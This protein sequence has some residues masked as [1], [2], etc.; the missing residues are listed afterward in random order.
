MAKLPKY[1]QLTSERFNNYTENKALY[2]GDA[3]DVFGLKQFDYY[4]KLNPENPKLSYVNYN[5]FKILSNAIADL[6]WAN[7]EN[8]ITL[9]T[10][11][12]WYDQWAV[13]TSLHTKLY[14]GTLSGSYW[15]DTVYK[16]CV[17]YTNPSEKDKDVRLYQVNPGIWHPKYDEGNPSR[18]IENHTLM[19]KKSILDEAGKEK[20]VAVLLEKYLWGS[21]QYEAY[22]GKTVEDAESVNPKTYFENEL[23]DVLVESATAETTGALTYQTNTTKPLVFHI[24]NFSLPDELYGLSDYSQDIKSVV[25]SINDGY[26]SI[27]SVRKRHIDPMLVVPE[28]VIK[29]SI[30]EIMS[31]TSNQQAQAYGYSSVNAFQSQN[32]KV[33]DAVKARVA[34]RILEKT[35]LM[36][37]PADG[38]QVKPEYITWDAKLEVAFNQIKDLKKNLG[39]QSE[40]AAVLLEPDVVTGDISGVTLERLASPTLNKAKRKIMYLEK[41]IKDIIFTAQQLAKTTQGVKNVPAGEPEVPIVKFN[42]VLVKSLVEVIDRNQKLIETGLIS[43]IDAMIDVFNY[44]QE[45]AKK[46]HKEIQDESQSKMPFMAPQIDGVQTDPNTSVVQPTTPVVAP[47]KAKV[48]V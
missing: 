36:G 32:R 2:K 6:I 38:T 37:I 11:Q 1:I 30:S 18:P 46:K 25:Y 35:R 44:T 16:L 42:T 43:E 47:K 45:T 24:P 21:I 8:I 40:L 5:W 3:Y 15:G 41:G 17:D 23:A 34:A 27:E 10:N 26:T 33:P 19:Y 20:G 31:D 7:D 13:D 28:S 48:K 14:E 22:Y 39:Q 9:P 29:A 4:K 12:K